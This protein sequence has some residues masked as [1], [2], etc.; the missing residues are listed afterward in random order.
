MANAIFLADIRGPA[1]PIGVDWYKGGLTESSNL[2]T[3]VNGQYHVSTAIIAGAVGL[4][5]NRPGEFTTIKSGTMGIQTFIS[6]AEVPQHWTR[7][8]TS[9]GWQPWVLLADRWR[10]GGLTATSGI[11]TL[12]SI[13]DGQY[14]V[15]TIATAEAL[16]LPASAPGTFVQASFGSTG[17]QEFTTAE[18]PTSTYSRRRTSS[19]WGT[20][21]ETIPFFRG[22]L[23]IT[24][25]RW[26]DLDTVPT[27]T[28][29]VSTPTAA[30]DMNLPE[31]S[32]GIVDVWRYGS[33]NYGFQI[34]KTLS[35]PSRWYTRWKT[36]GAWS[37]WTNPMGTS[38]G[39]GTVITA[40]ASTPGSGMK[41]IPLA[42]TLGQGTTLGPATRQ[43]R[44]P[45]KFNA[46]INRWRLHITDRNPHNGEH[47]GAGIVINNVYFGSHA[48][49]GS[50]TTTPTR[51]GA[52]IA[53][54][55]APDGEWVSAWRS[56]T[57]GGNVERLFSYDYTSTSAPF[58][59]V[60][61]AYNTSS[62]ASSTVQ[63]LNG[64][65][66]P[67]KTA[68][69]D[70]WIE[71]ETYSTTPVI[72]AFGDSLSSGAGAT[73]PCHESAVSLLARREKALPVHF[74]V[75]GN[76]MQDW[77]VDTNSYK[78]K[79]WEHLGRADVALWGMG[80]N[81]AYRGRTF[82]QMRTDLDTCYP[83]VLSRI[84]PV[85]VGAT[86]T[87]RNEPGNPAMHG[88][89]NQWNAWMLAQAN[90][91]Q[92]DGRIRDTFDFATAINNGDVLKPQYDSGD[93]LHLNTAGYIAEVA[94]ITRKI[95]TPP[96]M[97]QS[98]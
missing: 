92:A 56:E 81:D 58:V 36:T 42:L 19:G 75:S 44:I 87:T 95:T 27:G 25:G 50:F 32:P 38:G 89:R 70:M 53:L 9:S 74:A 3:L 30:T 31:G 72:A 88:V 96:V 63:F 15:S 24:S 82:A 61:G 54:S 49:N 79:R 69:F 93:Q 51:I 59:G 20:W 33:A 39:G 52:S 98:V 7:R 35:S 37:A 64:D 48:T 83:F 76:A 86:I 57:L 6:A 65:S 78:W 22:G 10:R 91:P 73:L 47:V 11:T 2:T 94:T 60:S 14:H 45:C 85:V 16:G 23:S 46:P 12:N 68:A 29:S 71:A 90:S 55:A 97:Y 80:H 43:Y 21:T 84:A 4:P 40:N 13:D 1:G 17:V 5:E 28:Y 34:F 66:Q 18:E 62:M 26:G 77:A 8:M 41:L 67:L